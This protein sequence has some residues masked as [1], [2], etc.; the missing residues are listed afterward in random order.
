MTPEL[1]KEEMIQAIKAREARPVAM[2]GIMIRD[3]DMPFWSMV[4][5]MLKWAI[6][7]IPAALI[8]MAF[9]FVVLVV[10]G[11]SLST[12]ATLLGGAR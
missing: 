7:S 10:A 9:I 3:F 4:G 11:V 8:L 2:Q 12:L 5:F 6:A 1:S